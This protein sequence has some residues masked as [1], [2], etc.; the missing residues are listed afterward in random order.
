MQREELLNIFSKYGLVLDVLMKPQ[1][2]YAFVTFSSV[3][4][5]LLSFRGLHGRTMKCPEELSVPNV[6]FYISFIENGKQLLALCQ[7]NKHRI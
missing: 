1:K 6:T 2:P 5:S 7:K 3:E 4:E